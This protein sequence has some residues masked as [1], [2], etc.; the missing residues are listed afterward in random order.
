M[1]QALSQEPDGHRAVGKFVVKVEEAKVLIDAEDE[2][3]EI[4][5]EFLGTLVALF[6]WFTI[7]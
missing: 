3:G 4:P 1:S 5:D 2:L 6:A 7:V